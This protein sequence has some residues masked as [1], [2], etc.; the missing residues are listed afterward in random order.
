MAVSR[1]KKAAFTLV[2]MLVVITILTVLMALLLSAVNS[3]RESMRR[4]QC[5]NNLKQLGDAAQAHLAAQGHFPSSGWGSNWTGDPDHGFGARQPGGWIFNLLPYLGLD[6]IHDKSKGL[7]L[8]DPNNPEPTGFFAGGMTMTPISPPTKGSALAEARQAAIA[9]LICPTRRRAVAYPGSGTAYYACH[10]QTATPMMLSK[11]D[12][13][14]NG[15][16]KLFLG[17]GPPINCLAIYPACEW[18]HTDE[19]SPRISDFNGVSG[20][21]SEI[22][23]IPDGQSNVFF[24]GEKYIDPDSYY[25]GMAHSGGNAAENNGALEG[26]DFEIDRWVSDLTPNNPALR[27]PARD[28][29]GQQTMLCVS[30]GSAHPAGLHFVFCDGHVQL[31]NYQI[32]LTTYASLGIRNDGNPSDNY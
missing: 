28:T 22:S 2:E 32:D 27:T 15:G 14:A 8:G 25:T 3:V 16:S 19:T 7:P 6:M 12:Y 18:S 4:T 13:A 11:T 29:K 24:A 20:E 5:K 26:N 31:L 21:R 1:Q 30:F 9:V 17:I 23:V 10:P